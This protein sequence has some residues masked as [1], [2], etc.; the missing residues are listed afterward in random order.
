MDSTTAAV[1]EKYQQSKLQREELDT[2]SL[3]ELLESLDDD[4]ELARFREQR[5][6]QLKREM[7]SIDHAAAALGD[8]LGTV[9]TYTDEKELM[10]AVAGAPWCVVHFYQPTFAKCKVMNERLAE[11]AQ[12]HVA[13]AVLAISAEKAPF[14]VAKLKIKVLPFVVVYRQGVEASR[15]VGFEG[16]GSAADVSVDALEQRLLRLGAVARGTIRVTLGRPTR[17]DDESSDDDY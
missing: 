3:L 8:S 2:E 7:R 16:V 6:E 17:V 4:A 1:V 12:R 11:L 14:L 9:Q 15:I 5:M 10:T 13:L